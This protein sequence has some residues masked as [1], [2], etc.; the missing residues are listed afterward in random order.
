MSKVNDTVLILD[1]EPLFLDWLEDYIESRGF[2]TKFVTN[3]PDAIKE[4][5]KTEYMAL[6]VDLNVPSSADLDEEIAKKDSLYR[7][8]RG[9]YVANEARNK[10]YP[11]RNVVIYS[12]HADEKLLPICQRLGIDHIAKGRPHLLKQKLENVFS[13]SRNDS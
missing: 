2:K 6:L 1:D 8:Y 9:L 13:R 11:G 7:E 12:V 5:S 3:I 10:G 4:I